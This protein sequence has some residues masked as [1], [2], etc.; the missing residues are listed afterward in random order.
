MINKTIMFWPFVKKKKKD[1]SLKK[2][3]NVE[4]DYK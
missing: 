1:L 3:K 4:T 2:K